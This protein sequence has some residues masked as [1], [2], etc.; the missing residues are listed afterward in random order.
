MT[1]RSQTAVNGRSDVLGNGE[2]Q[3]GARILFP[4]R[5]SALTQK[6]PPRPIAGAIALGS[7]AAWRQ[8]Q[9]RAVAFTGVNS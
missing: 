8:C 6:E 2:R 7:R 5:A 4:R 3:P 9:R 1:R